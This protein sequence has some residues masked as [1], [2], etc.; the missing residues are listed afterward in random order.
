MHV[1]VSV[2]Q[3]VCT[4]TTCNC[5]LAGIFSKYTLTPM[6]S[7]YVPMHTKITQT[8]YVPTKQVQ[9]FVHNFNYSIQAH[10]YI[11]KH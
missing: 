7:E 1:F 10:A 8:K 4:N 5:N 6:N 3:A 11:Q 9:T 2:V